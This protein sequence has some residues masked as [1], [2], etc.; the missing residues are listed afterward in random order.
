MTE[1]KIDGITNSVNMNLSKIRE[2]M[3]DR[4]AWYA[5]VNA[6]VPG[7]ISFECLLPS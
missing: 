1:D 2:I 4:E 5:T 6:E 3:K 7:T